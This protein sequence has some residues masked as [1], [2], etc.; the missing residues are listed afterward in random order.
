MASDVERRL[1][2]RRAGARHAEATAAATDGRCRVVIERVQPEVDAGRFPIKRTVG[3]TV[4]VRAHVHADGHDLLVVLLKYRSGEH[5]AER[6]WSEVPM[7]PLGNDE[8]RAGFELR[9]TGGSEYTVEAWVDRFLSWR[10]EL[11]IKARAGLEVSTELREGAALVAAAA[12]RCRQRYKAGS[13]LE[14]RH[15][16]GDGGHVAPDADD[17]RLDEKARVIGGD[18]DPGVRINTALDD[19]LLALM[20]RHADRRLASTYGRVLRVTVDRERARFGAWYE[21]FPRSW[22]PDPTR[23]ATF[24]EAAGHL[25]RVAA[26]GFDVVYLPPIHPIGASFRKGRGN[27]LVAAPGDP[28]SPWAIGSPAG[29]HKSVEPGLGSVK[30]FDAFVA[31]ARRLGLEVALD[32]AYQ[33]SPDHPYVQDHPEWFRHR[34]DG[35]IKYAENPPKKYQD[36]YPFDFE[37]AAW[38]SLWDELLDVVSRSVW[39]RPCVTC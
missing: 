5:G 23:S 3:E 25:P 37:S 32:L 36:I 17:V 9:E 20:M 6:P 16:R 15:H 34:P 14:R 1:S 33:C 19:R 7:E 35:T 12:E 2:G 27:A 13:R 21:M 22:G 28:G 11:A 39:S 29:G 10:H 38:R 30:D 18:G 26:L 31:I 8:W 24:H 4:D